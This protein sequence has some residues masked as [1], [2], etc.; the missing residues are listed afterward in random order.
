MNI[1][2]QLLPLSKKGEDFIKKS[3]LAFASIARGTGQSKRN[4]EIA[5]DYYN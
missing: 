2:Q 1:P 3:A 4:D 5:W